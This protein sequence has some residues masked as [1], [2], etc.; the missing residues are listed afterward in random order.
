MSLH[1]EEDDLEDNPQPQT[2]FANHLSVNG[3]SVMNGHLNIKDGSLNISGYGS[4]I[5][6]NNYRFLGGDDQFF[7]QKLV[8]G[9]W[10]T[11]VL[12]ILSLDPQ[13]VPSAS[14]PPILGSAP[15]LYDDPTDDYDSLFLS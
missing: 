5:Q 6:F 1:V 11:K 8:N 10:I 9:R 14:A 3:N 4:Y 2:L 15:V 13:F 12:S 7:I